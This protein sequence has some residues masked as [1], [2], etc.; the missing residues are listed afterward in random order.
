MSA[1]ADHEVR[2]RFQEMVLERLP[3]VART[4]LRRSMIEDAVLRVDDGMVAFAAADELILSLEALVWAE[5][6]ASGTAEATRMVHFDEPTSPWQMFKRDSRLFRGRLGAA[7]LRRYPVR[8]RGISQR[9]GISAT[10]KQYRAFP[11]ADLPV[12][13]ERLGRPV[14]V[15]IVSTE[16]NP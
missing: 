3:A 15:D 13:P 4:R 11:D 14:H 7:F 16:V 8:Y 5:Q 9:V 10:W 1:A 12:P 6:L 2:Q